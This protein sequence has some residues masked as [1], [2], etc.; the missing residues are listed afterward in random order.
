MLGADGFGIADGGEVELLIP[1]E[2]FF[3]IGGQGH[4]LTPRDVN[5]EQR[6]GLVNELFHQKNYTPASALPPS[7]AR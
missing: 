6:L 5:V 7:P 2:Q 1:F 3:F 4:H